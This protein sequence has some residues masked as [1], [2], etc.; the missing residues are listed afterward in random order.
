MASPSPL[1]GAHPLLVSQCPLILDEMAR[2]KHPMKMT[3]GRR[4]LKRQ[5]DLHAQGRTKP[6]DI[7]TDADGVSKRSKH[8]EQ[9]DG[10]HHAIDFVFVTGKRGV[11]W[12]GPWDV[13]GEVVRAHGL[14]WG[15][16]FRRRVNGKPVPKPDRP[17]VEV[18]AGV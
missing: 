16:D 6:G 17:H 14:K 8:Q 10:F 4:S 2:R 11:T 12:E 5:Q 18:P 9:G 3:E 13:F 15:G 1:D 7:V